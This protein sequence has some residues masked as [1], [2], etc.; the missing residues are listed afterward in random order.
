MK[1]EKLGTNYAK[2]TFTVKPALFNEALDHA[3]E[4]V[5]KD[6]EVKGF[7]KGHVPRNIYENKFGV[8]SL[9]E[10]ALNFAISTFYPQ[11]FN[12]KSIIIVGEPSI[13]VDFSNVSNEKPFEVSLTFPIK[14]EVELGEY[15]GAEVEKANVEVTEEEITAQVEALLAQG[16][17]LELKEGDTLEEGDT[18]I[19]DFEGFVDE[20]PFEGGKAENHQLKI[21][22][23]QFIPGFEE[24]MVGMKVGETKDVKVTFPEEYHETSLAGK[25][26]IFKVKLHEIKT[27]VK[28]ELNDEFVKGLK[29]EG[30]ETVDALK[31]DIKNSL[32]TQKEQSEKNRIIGSA[33]KFAVDNA[34]V[35]IPM[36]MIDREKDHM[37]K[38]VEQQAAQYNIEFEMY[39]QFS[40]LTLE[41][42]DIE[43]GKQAQDRVL[44][45][46]V[47]DAIAE[48]E[49][50]EVSDD[51]VKAKIDEIASM[52][53]VDS[54]EVEK[55]I[56]K[57]DIVNE[58][59]MSKA[60]DFLESNIKEI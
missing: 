45:S 46:L 57:D 59:K 40:G 11:A 48:K 16:S 55:Q 29:K 34:K 42:F 9:Y 58:I 17:Q 21:G 56:P 20:E 27:E 43:I 19:I 1:F 14:P 35:D 44:T 2:F 32:T 24:G 30:I 47:I 41:Q 38:Q 36:E 26:A 51:D 28:Q 12:E 3:F 15:I 7:R 13:D 49:D 50:F 31:E 22:S 23:N 52:Y 4:E 37:R 54:K 33:I 25:E 8:E 60:I 18:S 53:Q 6:V 10:K 5:K 39:L